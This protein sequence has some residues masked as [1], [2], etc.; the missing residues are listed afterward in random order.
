VVAA[1]TEAGASTPMTGATSAGSWATMRMTAGD[2]AVVAAAADAAAA[3]TAGAAVAAGT[4]AETG[5][6]LTPGPGPSPQGEHHDQSRVNIHQAL[7]RTD[8]LLFNSIGLYFCFTTTEI[9]LN[10]KNLKGLFQSNGF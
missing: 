4:G 9:F 10:L 2:E 7:H 8:R 3:A 1:G 6:G 5:A